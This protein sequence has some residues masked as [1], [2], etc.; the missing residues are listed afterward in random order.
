MS[1]LFRNI[2]IIL[3][4]FFAGAACVRM[5]VVIVGFVIVK[6]LFSFSST[7]TFEFEESRVP[8]K[9]RTGQVKVGIDLDI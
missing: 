3:L 8:E 5:Q 1:A 4:Y 7:C 2:Q 6:F 9:V